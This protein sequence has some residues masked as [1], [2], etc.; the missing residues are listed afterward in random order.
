MDFDNRTSL[1]NRIIS[2]FLVV[3][4]ENV[5]YHIFDANSYH[6]HLTESHVKKIKED[7]LIDGILSA[8]SAKEILNA[9]EIW[10]EALGKELVITEEKIKELKESL[11]NYKYK[12][13]TKRQVE[14]VI[15]RLEKRTSVLNKNRNAIGSNT[16][17]YIIKVEKFKYLLYLNTY[18][19][20]QRVWLS[21]DQFENHSSENLVQ[22]LLMQS[23]FSENYSEADFRLLARTEP[24]RTI[25]R[26]ATRSGNLFKH[27]ASEMTDYQRALVSWSMLY[28]SVYESVDCPSEDVIND[29][30]QLDMWLEEQKNKHKDK[31]TQP[32][33]SNSKIA[34]SQEIAIMVETPEDA[35]KVYSLNNSH[36]KSVLSNRE[37]ALMDRGLLKETQLPDQKQRIMMERNNRSISAIKERHG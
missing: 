20:S 14:S 22:N 5:V 8:D 13:E 16:I 37:H 28:D 21:F 6:K 10:T 34:N 31:N 29:D 15:K 7:Y 33:I 26:S 25:W 36:G 11:P 30:V 9:K 32:L 17:E 18:I 19:N 4:Y 3:D 27:S 1:V 12:S 2:G 23:Y 24:W 35:Q